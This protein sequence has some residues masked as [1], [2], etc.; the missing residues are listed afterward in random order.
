MLGLDLDSK[1]LDLNGDGKID[2]A[3]LIWYLSGNR[4]AK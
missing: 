3:D 1:G 4:L 2:I